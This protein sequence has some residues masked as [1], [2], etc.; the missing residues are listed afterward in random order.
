MKFN[1]DTTVVSM[2]SSHTCPNTHKITN[3]STV[4]IQLL[5]LIFFDIIFNRPCTS[6]TL[7]ICTYIHI[8]WSHVHWWP[9]LCTTDPPPHHSTDM[10][11]DHSPSPSQ[12]HTY[13]YIQQYRQSIITAWLCRG[14]I[15]VYAW[16]WRLDEFSPF[17]GLLPKCSFIFNS[18]LVNSV[19]CWSWK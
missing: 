15:I 16:I 1:C 17:A 10:H 19:T 4:S 6:H 9:R 5:Y 14:H 3:V 12:L 11:T 2:C 18:I 7:Y 13:T 8:P